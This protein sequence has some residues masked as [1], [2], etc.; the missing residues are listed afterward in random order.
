MVGA[1]RDTTRTTV[2]KMWKCN[3]VLSPDLVPYDY[4]IDVIKLI[5]VFILFLSISE[6]RLKFWATRNCHIQRFSCVEALFIEKVVIIF[7]CQVA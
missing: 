1:K 6:K 3:F 2:V 7:V 4:F 5:P